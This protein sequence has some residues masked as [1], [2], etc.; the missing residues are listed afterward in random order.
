MEKYIYD[1][2][3][4]L[5]YE[6]QRVFTKLPAYMLFYLFSCNV[7]GQSYVGEKVDMNRASEIRSVMK[8][9]AAVAERTGCAI[10]LVGHLNKMQSA[11]S[12][13]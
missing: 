13:Y 6:L 5:W 10:V 9:V 7:N 8:N 2:N 1:N 4:G 12:A 3:N 11:N